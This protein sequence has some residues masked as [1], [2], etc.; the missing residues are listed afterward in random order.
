VAEKSSHPNVS[1]IPGIEELNR[2][3]KEITKEVTDKVLRILR[4]KNER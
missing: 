3:K 1:A 2:L 4:Q